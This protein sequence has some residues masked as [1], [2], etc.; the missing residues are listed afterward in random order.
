[1]AARGAAPGEAGR[2]HLL[3][4]SATE[5]NVCRALTRA[6]SRL[7]PAQAAIGKRFLSVVPVTVHGQGH[8]R[9]S[10]NQITHPRAP[11]RV[12]HS[13]DRER[14]RYSP[15]GLSISPNVPSQ[16]LP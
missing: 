8:G 2:L 10:T 16:E 5:A 3:G 15:C 1:M 7:M 11:G 12:P 13:A 6:V 9:P 14:R 4:R